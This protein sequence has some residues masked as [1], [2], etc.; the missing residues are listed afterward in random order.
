MNRPILLLKMEIFIILAE[1][2]ICNCTEAADELF[3]HTLGHLCMQQN[4]N[5]VSLCVYMSIAYSASNKADF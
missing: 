3:Q 2:T 5:Y 1:D 4:V